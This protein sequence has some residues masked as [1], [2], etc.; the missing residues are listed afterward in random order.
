MLMLPREQEMQ[1]TQNRVVMEISAS[2]LRLWYWFRMYLLFW[3]PYLSVPRS[4]RR[5]AKT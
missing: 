1:V 5:M 3:K 4:S 2:K